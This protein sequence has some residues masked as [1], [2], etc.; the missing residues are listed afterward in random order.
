MTPE[1]KK[2]KYIFYSCTNARGVCRREYVPE[3]VLLEPVYKILSSIQLSEGEVNKVIEGC[4]AASGAE[5]EFHRKE[6]SRLENES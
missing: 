6:I 3:R 1:I 4:R 2:E 5:V